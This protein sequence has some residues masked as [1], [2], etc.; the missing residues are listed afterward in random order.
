MKGL[1]IIGLFTLGA[2]LQ[3]VPG[4]FQVRSLEQ[5]FKFLFGHGVGLAC[6]AE[7]GKFR[8]PVREQ[9]ITECNHKTLKVDTGWA[10][11]GTFPAGE[12]IPQG[13][14]FCA[15]RI[16]GELFYDTPG[17]S[18][19]GVFAVEIQHRTDRGAFAALQTIVE[20][21]FLCELSYLC[22]QIR[23]GVALFGS[24]PD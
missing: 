14:A 9:A 8:V 19:V 1:D 24:S 20:I 12:T 7:H 11:K 4:L 17:G 10:V 18:I 23:H 5:V 2:D 16:Q 15:F 3:E 21:V 13:L 22:F 6:R